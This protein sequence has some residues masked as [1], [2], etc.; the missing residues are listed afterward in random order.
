LLFKR[1]APPRQLGQGL[2]NTGTVRIGPAAIGD[3]ALLDMLR[4]AVLHHV[5][6]TPGN[7]AG[8][9]SMTRREAGNGN[10]LPSDENAL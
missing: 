6:V 2:D 4:R 5:Q 3:M 7:I 10:P 8:V 1:A 9:I